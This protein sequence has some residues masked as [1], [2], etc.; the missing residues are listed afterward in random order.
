MQF[1]QFF[2]RRFFALV[3]VSTS[4]CATNSQ[5]KESFCYVPGAGGGNPEGFVGRVL[6]HRLAE[7]EIPYLFFDNGQLGSVH[8]R[9]QL[10]ADELEVA[11][12]ADPDLKCH[13]LAYSMGGVIVRYALHHLSLHLPDGRTVALHT[14]AASLTTLSSPHKGTALAKFPAYYNIDPGINELTEAAIRK[15]DDPL[16]A[17]FY[18]PLIATFPNYSYRTHM[19]NEDEATNPME[20]MGFQLLEQEFTERG[21][22]LLNDGVV[23]FD[24]QAWGTVIADFAAPH[25]LFA[26]SREKWTKIALE[27]YRIHWLFL[28]GQVQGEAPDWIK[29]DSGQK[30]WKKLQTVTPVPPSS[31]N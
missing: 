3:F 10:L 17:E 18:S 4:I 11:V 20:Q 15:F 12:K 6:Q 29:T 14:I 26:D 5:A 27:V 19:L 28:H 30:L 9:A 25:S 24:S 22:S 16:D 1:L 31:S 21:L 8:Q 23:P 7:A 13:F 2:H